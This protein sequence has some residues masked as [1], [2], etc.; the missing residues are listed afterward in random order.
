MM[1]WLITYSQWTG[2]QKKICNTSVTDMTPGTW[3]AEMLKKYPDADTILLFAMGI[4]QAE[5]KELDVLL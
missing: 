4:S 1:Y 5:C 2:Q 3:L